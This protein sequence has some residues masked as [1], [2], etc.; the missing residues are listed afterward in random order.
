M[1]RKVAIQKPLSTHWRV[2]Q[3]WTRRNTDGDSLLLDTF[4][5]GSLGL[6]SLE[7]ILCPSPNLCYAPK[8]LSKRSAFANC[9]LLHIAARGGCVPGPALHKVAE[10]LE[11]SALHVFKLYFVKG[12]ASDFSKDGHV[13]CR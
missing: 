3:S 8:I 2:T 7:L 9:W 12:S 5:S 13:L 10:C 11:V 6:Q 1:S 4:F